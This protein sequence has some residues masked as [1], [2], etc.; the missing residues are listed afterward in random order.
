M[1]E[2][3]VPPQTY[4][5]KHLKHKTLLQMLKF[6]VSRQSIVDSDDLLH[7]SANVL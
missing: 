6:A 1:T 7:F 5:F 4:L 2:T 3:W